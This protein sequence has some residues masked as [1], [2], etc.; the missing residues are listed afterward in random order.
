M[1]GTEGR[2]QKRANYD[3]M[4]QETKKLESMLEKFKVS[5]VRHKEMI[6]DIHWESSKSKIYRNVHQPTSIPDIKKFSKIKI[7]SARSDESLCN[8][9]QTAKNVV[10]ILT[11]PK[12]VC[13]QCEAVAPAVVFVVYFNSLRF[14]K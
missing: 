8:G 3:I 11:P 5:A 14:A 13:G 4:E 2:Y 9:K 6:K 10:K 1:R 12:E 7:L